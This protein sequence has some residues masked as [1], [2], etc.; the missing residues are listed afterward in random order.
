LSK[1]RRAAIRRRAHRNPA[2]VVG[3]GKGGVVFLLS[4]DKTNGFYLE[5]TKLPSPKK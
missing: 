4:G 3:V 1:P 2:D 5:K